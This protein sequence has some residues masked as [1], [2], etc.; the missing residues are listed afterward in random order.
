VPE[1]FLENLPEMDVNTPGFSLR[2]LIKARL[3]IRA[4]DYTSAMRSA[5][6]GKTYANATDPW[7]PELLYTVALVY[8]HIDMMQAAIAAHRELSISFPESPWAQESL[9]ALQ[10]LTSEVSAL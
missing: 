10:E 2:E 7:Y 1:V 8:S 9:K 6:E 5:A 3:S 4:E